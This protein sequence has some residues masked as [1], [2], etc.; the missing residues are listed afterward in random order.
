VSSLQPGSTLVKCF[1]GE[2]R[3]PSKTILQVRNIRFLTL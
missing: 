2:K 3:L 1:Y